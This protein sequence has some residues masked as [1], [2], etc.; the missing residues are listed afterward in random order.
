VHK[1]NTLANGG[2][3]QTPAPFVTKGYFSLAAW[4]ILLDCSEDTIRKNI[5]QYNIPT[6]P[7]GATTVICA[8]RWWKAV[9]AETEEEPEK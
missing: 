1:E 8:R 4:A 2:C 5:K 3:Q 6:R 7:C 9:W